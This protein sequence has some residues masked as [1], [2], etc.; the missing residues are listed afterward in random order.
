[1]YKR[2]GL[3]VHRTWRR[4]RRKRHDIPRRSDGHKKPS[5]PPLPGLALGHDKHNSCTSS[6]ISPDVTTFEDVV[7]QLDEIIKDDA[8]IDDRAVS[9]EWGFGEVFRTSVQG[10]R[11][12]RVGRAD[13]DLSDRVTG[14]TN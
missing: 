8:F 4:E 5:I 1:M 11:L 12:A 6:S 13:H 7:K 10:S 3:P 9:K 14:H 2:A